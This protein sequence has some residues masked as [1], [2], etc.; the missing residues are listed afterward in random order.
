MGPWAHIVGANFLWS[1]PLPQVDAADH[2][3][4]EGMSR[5]A[6]A[7][8]KN[9]IASDMHN[10]VNHDVS[11]ASAIFFGGQMSEKNFNH[12]LFWNPLC[13]SI[14]SAAPVQPCCRCLT[15]FPSDTNMRHGIVVMLV[16]HP[17]SFLAMGMP[18]FASGQKVRFPA[19][20][21]A[22]SD[23]AVAAEQ[24]DVLAA[25]RFE[26]TTPGHRGN[27]P[28]NHRTASMHKGCLGGLRPRHVNG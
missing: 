28:K 27:R 17:F 14:F 2:G 21:G 6:S 22:Q 26:G 13:G 19:G 1:G 5:G 11:H 20:A 10:G 3:M 4:V 25:A 15:V 12:V 8:S 9:C 7:D 24:R 16:A 23:A 18:V